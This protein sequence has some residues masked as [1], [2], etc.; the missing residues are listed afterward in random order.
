LTQCVTSGKIDPNL[1]LIRE[2]LNMATKKKA[3]KK[4]TKKGKKTKKAG[5]K[6]KR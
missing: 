5:K 2:D 3:G 4:A 1:T 6:G